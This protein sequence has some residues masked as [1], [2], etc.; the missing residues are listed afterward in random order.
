MGLLHERR[1]FLKV[2]FQPG[3]F[4]SYHFRRTVTTYLK[5]YEYLV[6]LGILGWVEWREKT[7][8]RRGCDLLIG[9]FN[10]SPPIVFASL[11]MYHVVLKIFEVWSFLVINWYFKQLSNE[12]Q[13][14][15]NPLVR[16][17]N[18]LSNCSRCSTITDHIC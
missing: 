13:C 5:Y 17:K 9:Y 6:G 7:I 10:N 2:N 1:F 18:T 3:P 12:F 11:I 4:D 8:E 14:V 16:S 15:W